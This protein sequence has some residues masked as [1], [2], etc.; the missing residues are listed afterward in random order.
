[1]TTLPTVH[2][3]GTSAQSLADEYLAVV[4]AVRLAGEALDSATCNPRDFYTQ[5]GA[6]PKARAEREEIF[7]KLREVKQYAEAWLEHISDHL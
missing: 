3:N 7:R 4:R 1:M 6:W 5:D 2:I